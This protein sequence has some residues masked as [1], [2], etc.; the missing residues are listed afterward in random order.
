MQ[1]VEREEFSKLTEI[2]MPTARGNSV[3]LNLYGDKGTGKSF[4]LDVVKEFLEQ[5]GYTVVRGFPSDEMGGAIRTA[6][7]GTPLESLIVENPFELKSML[8]IDKNGLLLTEKKYVGA[9]DGDIVGS[10][11]QAV[12]NFIG[13][14]FTSMGGEL[15][16]MK[17]ENFDVLSYKENTISIYSVKDVGSF[18]VLFQG[19]AP[20]NFEV[21][22]KSVVDSILKDYRD[23]ITNWDGYEIEG[24]LDYFKPIESFSK[25]SEELSVQQKSFRMTEQFFKGLEDKAESLKIAFLIDDADLGDELSLRIFGNMPNV[26]KENV[27]TVL[28]S[29]DN[30]EIEG[31]NSLKLD[32]LD[33]EKTKEFVNFFFALRKP[34][35]DVIKHIY[36][37][38]NGNALLLR[39]NMDFLVGEKFDFWNYDE[40]PALFKSFEDVANYKISNLDKDELDVLSYLSIFGERNISSD[41][42]DN[43]QKDALNSLFNKGIIDINK[44]A[45]TFN[46]PGMRDVLYK[47]AD[48]DLMLS[49][50]EKLKESS[51]Y[52]QAAFLYKDYVKKTGDKSKIKDTLSILNEWTGK[53]V[54]RMSPV[55][56]IFPIITELSDLI[57]NSNNRLL[58]EVMQNGINALSVASDLNGI[59]EV[60]PFVMRKAE[61]MEDIELYAF[62]SYTYI[63]AKYKKRKFK[64]AFSLLGELEERIK[65]RELSEEMLN[66]IKHT[67]IGIKKEYGFDSGDLQMVKE[68]WNDIEKLCEKKKN[69]PKMDTEEQVKLFVE[70]FMIN[71]SF[72]TNVDIYK[73]NKEKIINYIFGDEEAYNKKHNEFLG[74]YSQIIE[75][76]DDTQ[77]KFNMTRLLSTYYASIKNFERSFELLNDAKEY[78]GEYDIGSN[79][80]I[81]GLESYLNWALGHPEKTVELY[82]RWRDVMLR[83]AD[84]NRHTLVQNYA[85]AL[86]YLGFDVLDKDFK[87]NPSG[88]LKSQSK[89]DF[90]DI[91]GRFPEMADMMGIYNCG[92]NGD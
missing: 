1:I 88:L 56:N 15:K 69:N 47:N 44:G 2:L 45:V 22:M 80:L 12:Q 34:P 84:P 26:C 38:T 77:M 32:N 53:M 91:A 20:K 16:S 76:V 85:M 33:Y 73:G 54:N 59:E 39:E 58:A 5:S 10:M 71:M 61:E 27:V 82:N 89:E 68:A 49:A 24:L 60:T 6:V 19:D 86:F 55:E 43:S 72:Y 25:K 13:D 35:E 46:Y 70:T 41:Y 18:V 40:L 92:K 87:E 57:D 8:L 14:T 48:T 65:D 21:K 81:L 64:E 11:L 9:L 78:I 3:F 50:A 74:E 66:R 62:S 42:L 83:H 79:F 67:E 51:K 37:S 52:M 90:W 23:K 30:M 7:E 4:S 29:K 28:A 36:S 31:Y 75:I 17:K 63:R